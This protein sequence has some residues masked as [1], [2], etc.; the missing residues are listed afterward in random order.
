MRYATLSVFRPSGTPPIGHSSHEIHTNSKPTYTAHHQYNALP[1]RC[2]SSIQ[3]SI[4][5]I[6]G[7]YNN[8]TILQLKT[9]SSRSVPAHLHVQHT[10]NLNI[11]PNDIP[12]YS[13]AT[14][15]IHTNSTPQQ[16]GATPIQKNSHTMLT[17]GSTRHPKDTPPA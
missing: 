15:K 1:N 10:T 3:R 11:Y 13:H 6:H 4:P 9:R 2:T 7:H 17:T 12:T 14:H 8:N 16:Y 5:S